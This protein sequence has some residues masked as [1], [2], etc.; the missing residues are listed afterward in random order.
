ML[1]EINCNKFIKNPLIFK[2]GL[3]SILGDNYS[4]NSI[5]KSTLL[6]IIDFAFGGN[7]FIDNNS[8]SIQQLGHLTFKFEFKF[9]SN[10]H[11][12]IRST[13]SSEIVAI[14]DKEYNV[15]NQIGIDTYTSQLK[16]HYNSK[17]ESS[18]RSAVN[19]YSRVWKKDNYNVDKPI[20][21][22]I[23][24]AESVSI[25][26]LI[27]LFG[28]Y[29]EISKTTNL[30]KDQEESKKIL[31]G[32]FKKNFL[33]KVTKIAYNQNE[34]EIERINNDV[35][36]I[37]NNLL[38]FTLNIEEL[39][40]KE[41][42]ELKTQKQKLLEAQSAVQNKI[43]R[44]EI[45]LNNTN[46]KSKYFNRL[47]QF[48]ENP[49]EEKINEIELFHN[50][51][52]KIMERELEATKRI[53]KNEDDDF[54]SQISILDQ[55]IEGLLGNVKSPKFIV[56]KIYDLT[57]HA[58]SLKEANKF[59]QQKETLTEEVKT[60]N[61]NLDDII[62]EILSK[63]EALINNELVSINRKIHS[64]KK[65]IPKITLKRKVYNFDH[66]SNTGTGKSYVDLIEFDLA[67]LKLTD[68]PFLIHDSVLFKN[69]EDKAID[70]IIEQ[71][72]LFQ[73]QIFIALDGVNKFSIRSQKILVGNCV[74][75]LSETRKLFN[76]DWR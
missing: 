1:K 12:Y 55:K 74:L 63:I 27:K 22:F 56:E 8:G 3:N 51:I 53:L 66:S 65:K 39:S 13:D 52:S 2:E 4:T 48:F 49:N 71:Y 67:I 41:L 38:K 16:T 70:K 5:G 24:E 73:K 33:P 29:H 23:K 6:M 40:N 18:F 62:N 15:I 26:N 11:Y 19:P 45:N 58:N 64:D 31:S 69:V 61:K 46:I 76:L 35:L 7:T 10:S 20:L 17:F 21:N 75:H 14:C 59:Y 32:M 57:V 47:S 25:E 60:L 9:N 50:N 43:K 37:Q 68:L 28:F 72:F 34:K 54:N 42:I 30:I 36:D 44:L